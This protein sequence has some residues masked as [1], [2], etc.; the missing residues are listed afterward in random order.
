MD[1]P[2]DRQKERS[3]DRE[4]EGKTD[5]QR[6]KKDEWTDRRR[7]N[8]QMERQKDRQIDTEI[9]RHTDRPTEKACTHT[10]MNKR[11]TSSIV[12]QCLH[13]SQQI[14]SILLSCLRPRWDS[15]LYHQKMFLF[16]FFSLQRKPGAGLYILA[17]FFCKKAGD[18]ET[19][20]N[21]L[22]DFFVR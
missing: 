17:F 9:D 14:S 13:L 20:Q 21:V 18:S 2:M 16:L 10:K 3:M 19:R 12:Q 7:I 22:R 15:T 11:L 4:T 6:D 5:G 1:G 8:K